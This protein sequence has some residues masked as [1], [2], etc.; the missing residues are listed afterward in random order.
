MAERTPLSSSI[1]NSCSNLLATSRREIFARSAGT[2]AT[3]ANKYCSSNITL[4]IEPTNYRQTRSDHRMAINQIYLTKSLWLSGAR[5][6][7]NIFRRKLAGGRQILRMMNFFSSPLLGDFMHCVSQVSNIPGCDTSDG[8]P[9]IL[10]Q[11]NWEFFRESINPRKR[12]NQ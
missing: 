7:N 10:C 3:R 6:Q 5:K 8:N 4:L 9:S 2:L 1:F 11:I 12:C